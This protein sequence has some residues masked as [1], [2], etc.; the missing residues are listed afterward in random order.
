MLKGVLHFSSIRAYMAL[1]ATICRSRESLTWPISAAH[2][3][4]EEHRAVLRGRRHSEREEGRSRGTHGGDSGRGGPR[5]S[6]E[7]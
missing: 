5:I 6:Q 1:L 4:K 3:R 7:E 2:T